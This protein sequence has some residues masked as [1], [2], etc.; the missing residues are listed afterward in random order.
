M[1]WVFSFIIIVAII[2]FFWLLG[3]G[4]VSQNSTSH[5]MS[6]SV[7][8]YCKAVLEKMPKRKAKCPVC[9]KDIY[10]RTKQKLFSSNLLTKEDAI[11]IDCFKNMR[12][13]G[14]TETDFFTK[15][16]H[17]TSKF[18]K[19]INSADIAWG[20]YNDIITK[21]RDLQLASQLYRDMALFL[22]KLGKPCFSLLQQGQK[23]ELKSMKR[24]RWAKIV[25][26]K[27]SGNSCPAC[28]RL[29]GKVFSITQALKTMPIPCEECTYKLQGGQ[30]GFCR[31]YYELQTDD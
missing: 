21:E 1:G 15:K 20:L 14:I 4:Q 29:A 16:T 7:C 12:R 17:L 31:C 22:N 24:M 28:R 23:A 9:K 8:P 5:K 11:V 26:I 18:G 13:F 19:Q 6:Q 30:H 2:I 3:K 25:Q 10:V 27:S